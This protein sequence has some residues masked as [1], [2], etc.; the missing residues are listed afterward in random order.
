MAVM[1]ASVLQVGAGGS[2]CPGGPGAAGCAHDMEMELQAWAGG[3]QPQEVLPSWCPRV[4][5]DPG[6][7]KPPF[8]PMSPQEKQVSFIGVSKI[9]SKGRK[10]LLFAQRQWDVPTVVPGDCPSVRLPRPPGAWLL[11]EAWKSSPWT[12]EEGGRGLSPSHLFS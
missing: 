7:Q 3:D 11:S 6:G 9:F 2:G 12:G 4:L 1:V 5:P 10:I 8:S